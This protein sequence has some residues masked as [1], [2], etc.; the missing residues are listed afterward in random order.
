MRR[1]VIRERSGEGNL[2]DFFFEIK[3]NSKYEVNMATNKQFAKFLQKKN[4]NFLAF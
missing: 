3:L 1:W 4:I 2:F